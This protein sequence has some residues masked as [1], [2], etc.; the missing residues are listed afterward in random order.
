M[1]KR[2][3]NS[4]RAFGYVSAVPLIKVL[5]TLTGAQNMIPFAVVGSERNVI[6]GG[7]AVRGRKNR[8]GVV[9]VEDETHCEFVS[10]RDFLTR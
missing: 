2:R 1:M 7:K 10:L 3:C 4:T 8:W 6:I 5:W 9:N